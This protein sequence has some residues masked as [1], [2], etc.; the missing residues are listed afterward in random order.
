VGSPM[1]RCDETRLVI[2]PPTL[3]SFGAVIHFLAVEQAFG[4]KPLGEI[5]LEVSRQLHNK[6]NMC[7]VRD[8]KL[9]G[10]CGWIFTTREIAEKYVKGDPIG[11]AD[12]PP[13]QAD[14][15][16]LTIVRI[17]EPQWVLPLMRAMRNLAPGK[18]VFFRREYLDPKKPKRGNSVRNMTAPV[19]LQTPEQDAPLTITISTP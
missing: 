4:R 16:V 2:L 18:Q 13:D 12:A 6:W 7:A 3:G 8:N 11:N 10:Y 19:S 1:P 14:T 9:V 17:I 5:V 15:P